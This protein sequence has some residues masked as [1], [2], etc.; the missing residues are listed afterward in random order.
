MM[1]DMSEAF[2]V[3]SAQFHAG[4]FHDGVTDGIRMADAFSLNQ[5]KRL[6]F[7]VQACHFIHINI[8]FNAQDSLL[9]SRHFLRV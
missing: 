2:P 6:L 5:F 1:K 7:N 9:L 3:F 4:S 8:T